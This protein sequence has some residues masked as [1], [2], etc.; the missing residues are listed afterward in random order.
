MK[1]EKE[2]LLELYRNLVRARGLDE[3]MV[4]A[5]QQGKVIMFHS[6][7]GEEAVAAGACTFL[8]NDDYVYVRRVAAANIPIPGGAAEGRCLP[9]K[10][11]IAAAIEAVLGY[12]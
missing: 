7:Q 6:S 3:L 2:Q 8:R 9:G 4:A 10:K 12:R 5:F 11:A 1:L